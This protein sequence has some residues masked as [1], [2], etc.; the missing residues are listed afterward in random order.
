[1]PVVDRQPLERGLQRHVDCAEVYPKHAWVECVDRSPTWLQVACTVS[2]L[3]RFDHGQ[4]VWVPVDRPTLEHPLIV[5]QCLGLE[6]ATCT[7]A[8]IMRGRKVATLCGYLQLLCEG[9]IT[10][11]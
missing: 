11:V 2:D 1:M 5:Q 10:D 4:S 9:C 7:T 3:G 6:C 8:S